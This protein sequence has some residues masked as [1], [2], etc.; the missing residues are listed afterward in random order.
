MQAMGM[1]ERDDTEPTMEEEH[2][3]ERSKRR[4]KGT[5]SAEEHHGEAGASSEA[6]HGP[7]KASYRDSVMGSQSQADMEG[8]DYMEAGNVSDDDLIE[9][10]TDDSWLGVGM[11]RDEKI[12][13][14]LPWSNNV[15]I[16]LVGHS[17]GYN[18]I[19]QHLQAMWH[20]QRELMLI[21][22]G[23]DFFIVKL[24]RR[25]EYVRA[26]TEGPWMIGDSYLHV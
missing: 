10:S 11:I 18:Y 9:E 5:G 13:D 24:T 14:R 8:M 20:T 25:E 23:F 17:I 3:L 6:T 12:E 26:L 22:L 16:K 21:D 19:S 15:I 4:N 1:H 7:R 2:I